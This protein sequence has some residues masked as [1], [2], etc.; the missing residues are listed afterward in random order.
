MDIH[1]LPSLV[2]QIASHIDACGLL[3]TGRARGVINTMF[4]IDVSSE[5]N[6]LIQLYNYVLIIIIPRTLLKCV[7]VL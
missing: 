5:A 3:H 7:L 2:S 4:V 1:V 6:S